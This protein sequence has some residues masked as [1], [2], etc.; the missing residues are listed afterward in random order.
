M[1]N[2]TINHNCTNRFHPLNISFSYGKGTT[3]SYAGVLKS[4]GAWLDRREP[5]SL[6]NIRD[7]ASFENTPGLGKI[8]KEWMVRYMPLLQEYE[9]G[10]AIVVPESRYEKVCKTNF[11][12]ISAGECRIF[13]STADALQWLS[14]GHLDTLQGFSKWQEVKQ[15]LEAFPADN[16]IYKTYE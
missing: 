5:Y 16:L 8:A 4:Y 11:E 13:T 1:T 9:K 15:Y 7:E 10:I 3:E 2:N 12:A 6:L 14:A